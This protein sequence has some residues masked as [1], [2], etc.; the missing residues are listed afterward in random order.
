MR[1]TPSFHIHTGF[2]RKLNDPKNRIIPP[3]NPKFIVSIPF[4]PALYSKETTSKRQ[5][6]LSLTTAYVASYPRIRAWVRCNH[7]RLVCGGSGRY[8]VVVAGSNRY[9]I[10]QRLLI[11]TISNKQENTSKHDQR[12]SQ[13]SVQ[14]DYYQ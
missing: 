14:P 1:Y 12:N 7:R 2:L 10:Y 11:S 9:C 4:H 3:P 13:R 5:P 6:S 8:A